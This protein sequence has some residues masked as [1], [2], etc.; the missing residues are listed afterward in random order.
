MLMPSDYLIFILHAITEA[1]RVYFSRV[2]PLLRGD[3]LNGGASA[4]DLRLDPGPSLGGARLE[5]GNP[6][7]RGAG[8]LPT[9]QAGGDG[10][11]V[12]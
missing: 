7:D 2:A 12:L 6:V 3:V 1:R 8:G 9:P 11:G 10:A 5:V 4:T